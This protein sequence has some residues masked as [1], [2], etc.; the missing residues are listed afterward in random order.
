MWVL[1]AVVIWRK[2]PRNFVLMR[3]AA[4]PVNC[5]K[6]AGSTRRQSVGIVSR[7]V[8]MPHIAFPFHIDH[9][10]CHDLDDRRIHSAMGDDR[11]R[12]RQFEPDHIDL[13]LPAELRI[14]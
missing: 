14:L 8:V 1:V 7:Y 3:S 13:H 12:P 10:Y 2:V 9:G 6:P 4:C 11:R 5:W